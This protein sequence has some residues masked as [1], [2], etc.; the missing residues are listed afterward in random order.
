MERYKEVCSGL[1]LQ[2]SGV[3]TGE[4][5]A[6]ITCMSIVFPVNSG[7][8]MGS[9]KYR[10][11]LWLAEDK[12]PTYIIWVIVGK[13][14]K[15]VHFLHV[16]SINTIEELAKIYI[17]KV[18]KWHGTLLFVGFN[19]GLEFA[20]HLWKSMQ[21]DFRSKIR[22]CITFHLHTDGLMERINQVL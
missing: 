21:H 14:T 2:V 11:C 6:P 20:S 1:W 19:S 5:K 15:S 13:L 4:Y 22:F 17:D 3:P 9:H 16:R 8:E 10:F 7:E 12:E 18:M